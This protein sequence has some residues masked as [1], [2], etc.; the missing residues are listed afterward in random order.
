MVLFIVLNTASIQ[1]VPITV[2]TLRMSSG[3][4]SPWDFVP[5]V[6]IVSLLSLIAS[7]VMMRALNIKR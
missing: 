2:A 3:S 6:L 7:I 5:S 4:N 1:L